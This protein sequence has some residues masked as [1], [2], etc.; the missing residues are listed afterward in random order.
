MQFLPGYH[1]TLFR[2]DGIATALMRG[3]GSKSGRISAFTGTKTMHIT[4]SEESFSNV[5]GKKGGVNDIE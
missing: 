1:D 5:K 4:L 2:I 3:R